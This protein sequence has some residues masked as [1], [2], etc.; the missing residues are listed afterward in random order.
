MT[1]REL[2]PN[3]ASAL[4]A[5]AEHGGS[6]PS[7]WLWGNHS[8]TRRLL[9]SLVRRGLT[10]RRTNATG[11]ISYHLTAEGLAMARARWRGRGLLR[12]TD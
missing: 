7:G 1:R 12:R 11:R 6:W 3:Q 9:E 4:H 5:L 2:G 8:Q 10:E